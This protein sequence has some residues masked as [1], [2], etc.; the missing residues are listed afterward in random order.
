M[1]CGGTSSVFEA[2]GLIRYSVFNRP[3]DQSNAPRPLLRGN[4]RPRRSTTPP[5]PFLNDVKRIPDPQAEK[6][7]N[8]H[9]RAQ[10]K[11][12]R[13]MIC[14]RDVA[15][16]LAACGD[17]GLLRLH[18]QLQNHPPA[19]HEPASLRERVKRPRARHNSPCTADHSF[20]LSGKRGSDD[21]LS[22][23]HLFLARSRLPPAG[24]Q[25][26]PH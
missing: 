24:P 20:S 13:N 14:L 26:Q 21:T 25:Y 6:Q 16:T 18:K 10:S 2:Q 23:E 19:S 7:R 11:S 3:E 22:A 9:Q 5:L 1:S 8:H 4:R 12:T 17:L 15:P